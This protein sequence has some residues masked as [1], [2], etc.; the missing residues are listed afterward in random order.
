MTIALPTDDLDLAI[1]LTPGFWSRFGAARLFITGGTGFIGSWLVQTIQRANDRGLSRIELVVLTRDANRAR[2]QSPFMFART[3]TTLVTG[4]VLDFSAQLGKLDLCIHAATDVGDPGKT[5][6][7]RK[8]FDSI[9]LG[10][11]QVL[12]FAEAHGVAHFLL[13]SSGAVYGPQPPELEQISE[14]YTGAPDPLQAA[15]AY[16]NGKRAAEWLACSS[17]SQAGF[18][19]TIARIFAL[20]G[21]GMPLNGPFAAGNFIRDVLA[22]KPIRIQGDG[23]PLRSYLY[24]A[25]LVVWLLR[26]L[27][28][29][30]SGQ[31]YNV[32]SE[33]AISIRELAQAV[34]HAAQ[35]EST[36]D[37]AQAGDTRT[38]PP[39]YVPDTR[40]A[41][42]SLQLAQTTTLQTALTKTLQWNR[43][44]MTT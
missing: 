27:E 3:D 44:A 5:G 17:A 21:P 34:I 32:G 10:T 7:S 18:N 36:L 22:G 4:D 19:V 31:A 12:D 30:T 33:H 40:K 41:Q 28:S 1:A 11:R 35:V 13:A 43:T 14:S 6:D 42:Q 20:I 25:D 23:R 24:M 8:V 39:R 37:I 16:G 26:M 29:G 38:L 15:A 2:Q 9:V